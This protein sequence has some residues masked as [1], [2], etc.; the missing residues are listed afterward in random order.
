MT[1]AA[2]MQ[3]KKLDL[4]M[5]KTAN[6]QFMQEVKMMGNS[7][8]KQVL[9]GAIGYLVNQGQ[10]KELSNEQ[11][12]KIKEKSAPFTELNYVAGTSISLEGTEMI[13][14]RNA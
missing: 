13:S 12:N 1:A 9:D 2:E 3:G 5:K 10:R 7:A 11:V 8:S 14:Y 4:E 6:D